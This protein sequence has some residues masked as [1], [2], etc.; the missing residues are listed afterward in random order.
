M[1][2]IPRVFCPQPMTGFGASKNF[3]VLTLAQD[4]GL[5]GEFVTRES[6]GLEYA[7]SILST[8]ASDSVGGAETEDPDWCWEFLNL[9]HFFHV[10]NIWCPE[11]AGPIHP[12]F[13]FLKSTHV[14]HSVSPSV[15]YKGMTTPFCY[16]SIW[17][18]SLIFWIPLC[19]F[20]VMEI[21]SRPL[22]T[23]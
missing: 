17:T 7:S 6:V 4:R 5:M 10:G 15:I 3:P 8:S 19:L 23:K 21:K 12:H 22:S 14:Q 1:W 2:A 16:W 18:T 9:W 20:V 11:G 13:F